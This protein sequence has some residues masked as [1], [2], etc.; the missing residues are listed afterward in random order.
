[1]ES[2]TSSTAHK[3]MRMDGT[4]DEDTLIPVLQSPDLWLSDGNIIIRTV[5]AGTPPT[6][7][8]YRVHKFTLALHCS[9]F[10]SLF[11]GPQAAFDTGSERIADA[12]V[13]D[14][15]DDPDDVEHFLKALYFP[16]KTQLHQ[17]VHSVA[18]KDR[19]SLFPPTY[20]GILR[21]S[22]KYDAPVIRD[23]VVRVF[24]AQWPSQLADWDRL[25]RW[26]PAVSFTDVFGNPEHLHL[27]PG[28][29]IRLAV[30][31][32]VQ[33]VLPSAFYSLYCMI[34]SDLQKTY[35]ATELSILSASEMCK[36]VLGTE[37]LRRRVAG[38]YRPGLSQWTVNCK[39]QS[40]LGNHTPQHSPCYPPIV[41]F[42]KDKAAMA[43]S[44][45][46][47][48]MD[49]LCRTSVELKTK[50][51][52]INCQESVAEFWRERREE[53]WKALP[54]YFDLMDDVPATWGNLPS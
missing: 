48:F 50:G 46:L 54:A 53:T 42:H 1:M 31:A 10:A 51:V 23:I 22:T 33:E 18:F 6:R 37:E 15:S 25:Q 43:H 7:T 36:F 9:V 35:K 24:R 14:L 21:L 44:S 19:W 41:S 11:D 13:M 30:V 32:G 28:Q 26:E 27:H 17:N 39:H 4:P 3:R 47:M 38:S 8:I 2:A 16:H 49:W 29:A 34:D 45:T 12:P 40:L 52:C 20:A 5:P